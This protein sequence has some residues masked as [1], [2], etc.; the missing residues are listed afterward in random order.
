MK[1]PG[2]GVEVELQV[3]ACGTA[4]PGPSCIGDLRHGLWQCWIPNPLIEAG[5]GTCIVMGHRHYVRFYV[6]NHRGNSFFFFFFLKLLFIYSVV[7]FK[8]VAK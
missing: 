1:V 4:L 2:L 6:L 3:P 7:R 5:D 8:Y